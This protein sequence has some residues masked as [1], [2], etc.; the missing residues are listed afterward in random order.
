MS[1]GDSVHSIEDENKNVVNFLGESIEKMKIMDMNFDVEI[2]EENRLFVSNWMSHLIWYR[3]L[4]FITTHPSYNINSIPQKYIIIVI[5]L[6]SPLASYPFFG[7]PPTYPFISVPQGGRHLLILL[8]PHDR[9]N[10]KEGGSLRALSQKVDLSGN[11]CTLYHQKAL[12]HSKL[13]QICWALLR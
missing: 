7:L 9:K 5:I 13:L 2:D 4:L 12:R 6:S 3:I 11:R 10:W 1:L 8:N